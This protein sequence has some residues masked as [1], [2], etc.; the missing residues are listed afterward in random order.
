MVRTGW[1]RTWIRTLTTLMTLAVMIII[2]CFSMENAETSDLRSGEISR[3]VI[4]IIYPEYEQMGMSQK[5][6]VY[7]RIQL[8]VRKCA[9]FSE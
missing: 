1:Q 8:V 4:R 9:Q 2:F 6:E 5:Q 3:I 7:D